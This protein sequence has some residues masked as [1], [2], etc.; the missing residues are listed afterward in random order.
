M[1]IRAK[2]DRDAVEIQANADRDAA[3]IIAKA[4]KEA[5][6]LYAEQYSQSPDLYQLLMDL[7]ASEATFQS[8]GTFIFDSDE[9]PFSTVTEDR[10]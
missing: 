8:G 1:K 2:A 5:A 9:R 7:E 6:E 3:E 10:R 4:E